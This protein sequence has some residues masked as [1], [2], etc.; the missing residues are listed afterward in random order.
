MLILSIC[1]KSSFSH[2]KS[3]LLVTYCILTVKIASNLDFSF[4][5]SLGIDKEAILKAA[6]QVRQDVNSRNLLLFNESTIRHNFR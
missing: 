4:Y 3:A 2:K 6:L 1:S 5:M